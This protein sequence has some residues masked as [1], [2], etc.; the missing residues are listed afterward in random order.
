MRVRTYPVSTA[1]CERGFSMLNRNQTAE[2]NSLHLE[3]LRFVELTL[4]LSCMMH[5]TAISYDCHAVR[6][7]CLYA[8]YILCTAF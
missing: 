5:S 8:Y 3:T 2:R 4:A 7:I 1:E 6:P